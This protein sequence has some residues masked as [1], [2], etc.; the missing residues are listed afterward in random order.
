MVNPQKAQTGPADFW[1]ASAPKDSQE[2]LLNVEQLRFSYGAK[3]I[4][5]GVSLSVTAGRLRGLLGPNGS[6]KTTLFKCCLGFLKPQSGFIKIGQKNLEELGPKGLAAKVAYVP[7]EHH[8]SFPYS[9][10]EMVEMG[11]T[12][13]RG[14]LPILSKRDHEAVALALDR[15]GLSG[16]ASENYGHLSGGQRRL[17]LVA[18]A[19]A[20]EAEIMFLDE[21]TSSLDFSNQLIVWETVR[22]I[23]SQGLGVVI[24]CHDPNHI[25]WF[26]DEVA[27]LK[28]GKILADGPTG[29][30]INRELLQTLYGR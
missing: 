18:R 26:C 8:P 15:V 24:C 13:H 20:Q 11:R 28:N 1:G 25:L 29:S 10:R 14:L 22:A 6:G 17:V 27:A 19:L 7:Q 23:A 2:A 5:K 30:T 12:P 4:L 9:V 21:P 16:L 3:E